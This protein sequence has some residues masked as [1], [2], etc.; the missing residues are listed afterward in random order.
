MKKL[1][2][3]ITTGIFTAQFASASIISL[4]E[5]NGTTQDSVRGAG[6]QALLVGGTAAYTTGKSGQAF[7]F[8]GNTILKAPLAGAGLNNFSFSAWVNFQTTTGFD[9]ILKNWGASQIGA[10]HLGLDS[11]G[12]T[13]ESFIG[14]RDDENGDPA[15]SVVVGGTTAAITNWIHV[16]VTLGNSTQTLYVNGQSQDTAATPFALSD[17]FGSMSFGAKLNDAQ[18]GA[19]ENYT[20]WLNGYLDDVAFFDQALTSTEMLQVYNAGV[21]GNSISTL[22]FATTSV[23]E[24]STFVVSALF[25][26]GML[27]MRSRKSRKKS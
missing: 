23:P 27:C 26:C 24:P 25:A 11:G 12:N 22:G 9:T 17:R 4:Y 10:F 6:N 14:G 7:N 20:G 2:W 21:S 19:A 5:F 3:L 18:D 13:I 16:G 8:D 1:A 15:P